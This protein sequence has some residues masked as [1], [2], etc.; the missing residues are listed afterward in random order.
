MRMTNY[1]VHEVATRP[2]QANLQRGI[3]IY[4]ASAVRFWFGYSVSLPG[5][6]SSV[7]DGS[8]SSDRSPCEDY[9]WT[10]ISQ[11]SG[12]RMQI[13]LAIVDEVEDLEAG[14]I[15]VPKITNMGEDFLVIIAGG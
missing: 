9:V 8:M 6:K 3:P 15:Q 13:T 14:K 11:G 10:Y 4:S 1:S 2:F 12:T 5:I 7:M